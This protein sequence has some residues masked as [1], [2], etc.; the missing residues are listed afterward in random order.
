MTPN[1]RSGRE[2]GTAHEPYRCLCARR[3]VQV[4]CGL[5]LLPLEALKD[6]LSFKF[7]SPPPRLCHSVRARFGNELSGETRRCGA[8]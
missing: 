7:S 3:R 5:V 1:V 2:Q 4:A 6:A 8:F